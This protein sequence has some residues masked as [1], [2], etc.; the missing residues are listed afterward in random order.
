MQYQHNNHDEII[1]LCDTQIVPEL[2]TFPIH[3]QN[4]CKLLTITEFPDWIQENDWFILY[5]TTQRGRRGYRGS[6][7]RYDK[8]TLADEKHYNEQVTAEIQYI[9]KVMDWLNTIQLPL[10]IS[11][12]MKRLLGGYMLKDKYSFDILEYIYRNDNNLLLP[13]IYRRIAALSAT[14][15]KLSKHLAT[16]K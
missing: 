1:S 6:S 4:M 9:D 2:T 13:A 11:P 8:K 12:L 10:H 5:S 7:G 14:M 15:D 16:A 3:I